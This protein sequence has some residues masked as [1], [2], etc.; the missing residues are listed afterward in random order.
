MNRN[1][2]ANSVFK[3]I[4]ICLAIVG[5]VG[6]EFAVVKPLVSRINQISATRTDIP[7]PREIDDSDLMAA[8]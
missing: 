6:I 4:V 5:V 1:Y 3:I 8:R 2:S 7:Q